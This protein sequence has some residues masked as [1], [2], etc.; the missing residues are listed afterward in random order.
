M[1][2][3]NITQRK[4][5]EDEAWERIDVLKDKNKDELAL[6]IEEGMESKAKLTKVV[7]EKKSQED[8]KRQ[9]ELQKKAAL[10]RLETLVTTTS[11]L[12]TQIESQKCELNEREATIQDK[13]QRII[14][15]KKKTQEL[16]K[17]K[18]VL[19]YKIKELK[20]DIGPREIQI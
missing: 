7:G 2:K 19:D 14:E 6:I 13:D 1:E 5:I 18:F 17:F 11:D 16:E 3:Q 20:R 15:L 9:L 4:D 10:T 12:K 8:E